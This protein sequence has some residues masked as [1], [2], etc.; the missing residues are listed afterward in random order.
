MTS[1]TICL[2]FCLLLIAGAAVAQPEVEWEHTYGGTDEDHCYAITQTANSGFALAGSTMS[3]GA[4]EF[5]F[6]LVKTDSNGDSLWS[7]SYGGEGQESCHALVQTPDGGFALVGGTTSFGAGSYDFWLVRTDS[8]GDSLWS[9]TYGGR[10]TDV[11]RSLVLTDDGGFALAGYIDSNGPGQYD[12]WLLRTDA[13]GDSLWSVT[14][15]GESWDFCTSLIQTADLGFALAGYTNHTDGNADVSL[16]IRTDENGDSLW[17]HT[18]D[19]EGSDEFRSVVES[20]DHSYTIAGTNGRSNYTIVLDQVDSTGNSLWSSSYGGTEYD[21]CYS[22]IPIE[23]GGF[24]LGCNS[25]SFGDGDFDYLLLRTDARGD[26]IWSLM[27]GGEEDEFCYA[28]VRTDDGGYAMAGMID[29]FA[30]DNTDF[31]LVKTT[32]DPVSVRE[33][34]STLTPLTFNL[35]PA[36]PN[37]F[38]SMVTIPFGLDKSAPTR[39]AIFDPLGRRVAELIP[40]AGLVNGPYAG[41]KNGGFVNGPY[42][43]VKDGGFVNGPDGAGMYSVVWNANGM[44]AGAYIVRLETGNE[45]LSQ[46]LSLVK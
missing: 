38:N 36:Y 2:S 27:A 6:W 31:Y 24:A 17:S 20:Q 3:F 25:N 34:R 15:G 28:S 21:F 42:A 14:F 12:F 23:D 19:L 1:R 35:Y 4:G 10:G 18:F 29:F 45:Q 41:G 32:P 46:R 22:V 7:H 37:P 13:N 44:P 5:D 43:G 9:R 33:P 16:L 11:C 30:D 26:S 8:T 39:L 40:S